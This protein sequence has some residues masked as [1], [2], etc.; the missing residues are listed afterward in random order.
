MLCTMVAADRKYFQIV[1]R[2]KR[3]FRLQN[4]TSF[5][6]QSSGFLKRLFLRMKVL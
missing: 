6:L 3:V 2:C 1:I 5:S 4:C